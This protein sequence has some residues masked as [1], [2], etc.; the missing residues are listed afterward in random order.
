MEVK[1][2]PPTTPLTLPFPRINTRFCFLQFVALSW[3][4]LSL[5][6]VT[7][8]LITPAAAFPKAS[9][10]VQ[11]SEE[12]DHKLIF[13]EVIQQRISGG[14]T[15]YYQFSL[16][17]GQYLRLGLEQIGRASCRERV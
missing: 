17:A 1:M 10:V 4:M 6:L 7:F 8:L 12:S 11:S 3:A 5:F 2:Y 13:G 16:E 9:R 15:H 14:E